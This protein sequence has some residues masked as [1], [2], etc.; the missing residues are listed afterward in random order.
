MILMRGGRRH[1]CT[2]IHTFALTEVRFNSE[3]TGR[4][5]IKPG[6]MDHRSRVIV[7]KDF[8]AVIVQVRW[9]SS[10]RV[11]FAVSRSVAHFQKNIPKNF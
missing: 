2:K 5:N 7:V 1:I 6:T 10:W 11:R 4:T 9:R 3:L 8:Y